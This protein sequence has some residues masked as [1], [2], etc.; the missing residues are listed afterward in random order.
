MENYL[1]AFLTESEY[2]ENRNSLPRPNVSYIL[3]NKKVLYNP[4]KEYKEQYLTFE[5][6][7]NDAYINFKICFIWL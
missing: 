4:L 7:E 1:T 6:L 2:L 3:E 5:I